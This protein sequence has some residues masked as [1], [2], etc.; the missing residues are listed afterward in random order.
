MSG[1][2]GSVSGPT[3]ETTIFAVKVPADVRTCHRASWA[4]HRTS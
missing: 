4:F 3:A 1:N 2:A